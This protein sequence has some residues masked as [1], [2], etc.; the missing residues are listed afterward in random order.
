[1]TEFRTGDWMQTFTG[2]QFWPLDPRPDEVFIEDIA[3]ALSMQ[4]RY[5]GHCRRFYSVAEHSVH[6]AR[7]VPREHARWALLHDA[8]EAYVVD[9]PRPLKRFLAGYKPAEDR[10]MAAICA[11]FSLPEDMP[12][13]V[14]VIDKRIVTDE[15]ANLS[16]S[17]ARWDSTPE[18]IGVDL[19]Y[20][21]P[22]QARA[23]FLAEFRWL[24]PEHAG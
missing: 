13:E 18:P 8:S 24:F 16:T 11:R 19:N 10:V 4:C 15:R 14:D 7:S 22:A 6:V 12:T 9:V 17:F 23:V 5:G 3:H 21:L 2:R 1:M 20:W